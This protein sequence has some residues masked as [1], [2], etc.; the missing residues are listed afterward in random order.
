MQTIGDIF[1]IWLTLSAC[2]YVIM[3]DI[4]KDMQRHKKLRKVLIALLPFLLIISIIL[5]ILRNRLFEESTGIL[6]FP[7]FIDSSIIALIIGKYYSLRLVFM[8]RR[9]FAVIFR[10]QRCQ[11]TG[12][13]LQ[14]DSPVTDVFQF[15]HQPFLREI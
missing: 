1:K 2:K 15:I 9:V 3:A 11:C 10:N 5:I 7:V 13:F 4:E 14:S 6:Q 8:L 12:H